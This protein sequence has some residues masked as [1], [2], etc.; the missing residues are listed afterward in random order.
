MLL[1]TDLNCETVADYSFTVSTCL[2]NS[3]LSAYSF[4]SCADI[5]YKFIEASIIKCHEE[6]L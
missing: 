1:K 4:S 5:L 2:D 6:L 3:H